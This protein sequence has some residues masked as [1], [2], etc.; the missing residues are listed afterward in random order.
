MGFGETSW[1]STATVTTRWGSI[2]YRRARGFANSLQKNREG[3][4]IWFWCLF[5]VNLIRTADQNNT[6]SAQCPLP[7][8]FETLPV[9]EHRFLTKD[10]KMTT[11]SVAI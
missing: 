11:P 10:F 6:Y 5:V 2:D 7:L 1:T 3:G 9:C 4:C 8:N